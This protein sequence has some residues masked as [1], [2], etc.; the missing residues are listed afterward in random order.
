MRSRC[1][2][3]GRCTKRPRRPEDLGRECNR[4][5][6][7]LSNQQTSYGIYTWYWYNLKYNRVSYMLLL[8]IMMYLDPANLQKKI[9]CDFKPPGFAIKT[10]VCFGEFQAPKKAFRTSWKSIVSKP[11]L[12]L[13]SHD[14]NHRLHTDCRR[15]EILT[16]TYRSWM[17]PNSRKL[18]TLVTSHLNPTFLGILDTL[19]WRRGGIRGYI[20]E[21]HGKT[22]V[23]PVFLLK[24]SSEAEG[25]VD[26]AIRTN[27]RACIYIYIKKEQSTYRKI[28]R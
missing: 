11:V 22:R 8:T 21:K 9:W 7:R 27:M 25:R 5:P 13:R 4:P 14:L 15:S 6:G 20:Q 12:E 18:Q 10:L 2:C 1:L 26:I 19:N 17:P 16:R 24:G 3:S 23:S 28:P